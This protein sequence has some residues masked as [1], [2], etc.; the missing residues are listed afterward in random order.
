MSNA[1]IAARVA[2]IMADLEQ[3]GDADL[4][5]DALGTLLQQLG[6]KPP[7]DHFSNL[8]KAIGGSYVRD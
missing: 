6:G 1:E 4:A 7:V 2:D 5:V 8:A 3:T